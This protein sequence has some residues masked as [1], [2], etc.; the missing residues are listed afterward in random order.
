MITILAVT[1]FSVDQSIAQCQKFM[2]TPFM[3]KLHSALGFPHVNWLLSPLEDCQFPD[4]LTNMKDP[5]LFLPIIY[6][7]DNYIVTNNSETTLTFVFPGVVPSK[8]SGPFVAPLSWRKSQYTS[9][10]L[11]L[12]SSG[13]VNLFLCF[14]EVKNICF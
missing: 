5:V 9:Q 1:L 6:D 8:F 13:K 4:L 10:N 7:W 3:T 11:R 14:K 2:E 12:T